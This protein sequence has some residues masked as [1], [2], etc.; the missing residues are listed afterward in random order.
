MA[1]KRKQKRQTRLTFEPVPSS[2]AANAANAANDSPSS[3]TKVRYIKGNDK[4]SGD[5]IKLSSPIRTLQPTKKSHITSKFLC[6]PLFPFPFFTSIKYFLNVIA[7]S[8]PSN[9]L[10]L[11][12]DHLKMHRRLYHHQPGYPRPNPC[13]GCVAPSAL[14]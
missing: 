10:T 12:Q 6:L 1:R 9:R 7:Y 13:Q 14:L 2:N 11:V 5:G 8:Y 4:N 3:P